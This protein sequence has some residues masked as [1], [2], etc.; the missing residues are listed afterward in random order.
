MKGQR[1]LAS[2]LALG[3]LLALMVGL[4]S[5][6]G[7]EPQN[8]AQAQGEVSVAATVGSKIS[9]QGVLKE[10]GQPA[11]GSRNMVFRFYTTSDCSGTPVQS[12]TKNNVPV[13]KGLFNVDL[14][15]SQYNFNGQGLWLRVRVGSTNLGCEEVL[16][17]PYALSLRPGAYVEG[18]QTG[19]NAIYAK[20]TATS[21]AS[22]GVRGISQSASGRGISG[23][24]TSSGQGVYGQSGTG[25]G[26]Y[27]LAGGPYHGGA[28]LLAKNTNAAGIALWA[29][30]D[31]SD[32]T[33]VAG[34]EGTGP[35]I[36]AFGG[37][38]GEDEFRLG[39]NGK[40]E[41]KADSYLFIPGNEFIKNKDT[42]TTR[43]DCQENGSV[44]IW[45]GSIAGTKIV[46]MPITLP[47]V[48]YGQEVEL[49]QLTI[50]YKC[51]D[52]SKNYIT[53]TYLRKQTD[54][55]SSVAIVSNSTDFKSNTASNYGFI[56][57]ANNTLSSSQGIL[58]LYLQLH[59][60][61]S[62]DYIQIG[63]VRVQLGH[64]SLY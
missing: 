64:H 34:N 49:E 18:A 22:Y 5:A 41:T 60:D 35:L 36:K 2:V 11:A 19:W 6:Q 45:A 54:A 48:L 63:G 50:Y 39:N 38:G 58:G 24:N 37:D 53:S 3:L 26:I 46:Y 21:L 15:V 33:L 9:Y 29:E 12:V 61:N 47:G 57:T 4:A 20:N 13:T 30:S 55:D 42:D 62:T 52:G 27:A 31:S 40:I 56:L 44:K 23:E 59:F 16:P 17:V 1:I 14:S 8:E 43:W 32:T 51:Q 25:H 7:P 28:A 10:G